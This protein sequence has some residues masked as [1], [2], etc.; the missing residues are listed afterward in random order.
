MHLLRKFSLYMLTTVL[1]CGS[2]MMAQNKPASAARIVDKID[3]SQLTVL[4]GNTHPAALAKNDQGRVSSDLPMTDLILVLS[5]SVEKQAAFTSFVADQYDPNSPEFHHW[6][7]PAQV[8][9]NFG[10]SQAD[11]AAISNWLAGR[12]FT[13]DEVTKDRMS[14]RFSGTAGLVESA[15]HT[16]I[17]N[18]QVNGVAHIGNMSDPQIPTALASVVVGVKALHNFF[19]H[20]MHHVGSPVSQDSSTGLWKRPTTTTASTTTAS[21]KSAVAARF[22]AARPEFGISVTGSSPYLVEDVAPY[23]F[24]T[25]YNVL[26]LWNAGTDGTGQ[27]IAIAGTSSIKLSDVATFR[28]T[29]GLPANVPTIVSGNGTTPTVCTASASSTTATCTIDDE[30]E[31]ALDVEWSGAVAKGANIILVTSAAKSSS[32]DALLDSEQYIVNNKT[33][34]IM[35]VSYGECELGMGTASNVQYYN[36]WQTAATEGIAVFVASGDSGAASCDQGQ[37]SSTP[38][39]AEYGLS[40]SGMTS[41]PYN[42]SVGGTDFNWCSLTSSTE[43]TASPYWSTSNSASNG[44][45]ALGYVPEVPWNDTCAS[46]LALGFI[47]GLATYIGV[48]GVT[49]A[50]TACNF[51]G[52]TTYRKAIYN[53]TSYNGFDMGEFVD[54]WGGSGGAS[55]CIVNDGS[56][57]ASCASTITSTGSSYGSLPLV[58]D[59][60]PKPA[61]QSN[62]TGIPADGVRDVPDVSFFASDGYL[63]SSAYLVCVSDS[64]ACA[65]STKTEP[66]ALEV[67]GTSVASPAMAGVMALI[68][69]KAGAPQ[70]NPNSQLYQ[71]ASKQTYAN[72]N[73]ANGAPGS[74]CYFND[75]TTGT[76]AMACDYGAFGYDSPNCTPAHS[77]DTIGILAGYSATTGY[78]QATGLGSLNVANVVNAWT[79][80]AGTGTA[81]VGISLSATSILSSAP[82]TVT[83]TV[84]G[85]GSLGTPTGSLLVSGGGYTS[86]WLTVASGGNVLTIPANSLAG[87]T[88]TLTATYYGDANYAQA[89]ETATVTVTQSTFSLS[90][91]SPANISAGSTAT[92]TVTVNST[93]N[94][95]GT[96]TFTSASCALTTSPTN[97]VGLPTCALTGSGT[98]TVTNGVASGPVTFTVST[99]SLTSAS[100]V[101]PQTAG[102]MVGKELATAFDLHGK[103]AGKTGWF[104]AA[105]GTALAALI[106]FLVPGRT[107]R[108]RKTFGAMLVLATVGFVSIGC[109]SGTTTTT[110]TL[111]TPTV[112]V[113]ATPTTIAK[114]AAVSVK[115]TLTGSG[116]TPTGSV[117]LTGGGY[118]SP[119]QALSAGSTTFAIPA[120]TFST[121]G[122]V[123][124]TATYGGDSNYKTATGSGSLTVSSNVAT[125]SGTYGF[126]VTSASSPSLTPQP[127]ATFSVVVN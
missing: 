20:P 88:D 67:G 124:L 93:T 12:G 101:L 80:D 2:V 45:S 102:R 8:G 3:E 26:P 44:S 72:C 23:D 106:L 105:S 115:V 19:A 70:G 85:S 108:W 76:I 107:R 28:S 63:S 78:D 5:R 83:V 75:I 36:L 109:G 114:N 37:A 118:T 21:K 112:T 47:Q 14:I 34:N 97:A 18:L 74:S 65:Y 25:I 100:A 56:T 6:L 61:W 127:A 91:S 95:A 22:A 52:N 42:T 103:G 29:F 84:A 11:I 55:G 121:T 48:S 111:A 96:V 38:Y 68:N 9:E 71:L 120:N 31:N 89:S 82:L 30:I 113:V 1:F 51:A 98:V 62:V 33:A 66:S 94:Y 17:H 117:S 16:E 104:H 13:V 116:S 87:G 110:T 7:T 57:V 81:T 58:K 99:T 24:A 49:D 126:T 32:D 40:V 123:T 119:S 4:H 125:T 92:S 53:S 46:P 54:Y 86:T 35:N 69:Q 122:T 60:W 39:A 10:P 79:S 73:G 59:G 15:F 77:G 27:T 41:T 64:S 43:C 50:E 90:A